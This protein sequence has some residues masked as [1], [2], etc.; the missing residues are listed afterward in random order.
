MSGDT[1]HNVAIKQYGMAPS[2]TNSLNLE[3][4]TIFIAQDGDSIRELYY[5]KSEGIYKLR[6]L[7]QNANHL[8]KKV[9]DFA[10]DY[11]NQRLFCLLASG[12]VMV[13]NVFFGDTGISL[14]WSRLVTEGG[15][16]VAL[17]YCQNKVWFITA[18]DKGIFLE[19]LNPE[20]SLDFA[21]SKIPNRKNSVG[22]VKYE[23][24]VL[25]P[26]KAVFIQN[27]ETFNATIDEEN[28]LVTKNTSK[29]TLGLRVTTK[30]AP[31][32]L[33][34]HLRLTKITTDCINSTSLRI[35]S[36][37]VTTKVNPPFEAGVICRRPN[38]ENEPAWQLDTK[39]KLH[40]LQVRSQIKG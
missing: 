28:K 17:C 24:D 21:F 14:A 35:T 39:G 29:I 12:N 27:E 10:Y 18:R 26:N 22:L 4:S 19:W 5:A 38:R 23:A 36:G 33:A 13:A 6:S 8:I 25:K 15:K 1:S 30:I 37:G 9:T 16:V 32:P 31:T 11:F 40:L 2:V 34:R 20:S 3:D 7:S